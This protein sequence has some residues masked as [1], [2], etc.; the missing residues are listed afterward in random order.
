MPA[1]GRRTP[2]SG[3]MRICRITLSCVWLSVC[4]SRLPQPGHQT[5]IARRQTC[6]IICTILP[7]ASQRPPHV[8][9]NT[10]AS[11]STLRAESARLYRSCRS[12]ARTIVSVNVPY[13][14]ASVCQGPPSTGPARSQ[15]TI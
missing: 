14:E 5:R 8:F 6:F 12:A 13:N 7:C 10:R 2:A 11:D 4:G 3:Q 9:T 15:R 1:V